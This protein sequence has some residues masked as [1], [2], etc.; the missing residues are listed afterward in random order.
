M[1][2]IMLDNI[3]YG[4]RDVYKNKIF[5]IITVFFLVTLNVVAVITAYSIRYDY[6]EREQI[7]T[8]EAVRFKAVPVGYDFKYDEKNLDKYMETLNQNAMTYRISYTLSEKNDA[9]VFLVFG[10]PSLI[11]DEIESSLNTDEV[12]VYTY[13]EAVDKEIKVLDETYPVHLI[14]YDNHNLSIFNDIG[15]DSILVVY[16]GH[17]AYE[18]INLLSQSD[19]GTFYELLSQTIVRQ[20]DRQRIDAFM[21]F[22]NTNIKE[23]KFTS[24]YII[25]MDDYVSSNHVFI[26]HYLIPLYIIMFFMG[27]FSFQVI[28]KGLLNKMQREF[29]IHVLHGAKFRD[30]LIRQLV[31]Y[32]SMM[33]TAVVLAGIFVFPIGRQEPMIVLSVLIT[34]GLILLMSIIYIYIALKRTNLFENLRGDHV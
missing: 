27:V 20:D 33:I 26:R 28:F 31:F 10:D 8:Q 18:V 30:I 3:R 24:P 12:K 22:V 23:F 15:R 9:L 13:D 29:T 2:L 34:S 1:I 16:Q 4:L 14:N 6:Y 5:F 7:E 25:A 32:L 17:N 11:N 19:S 21:D